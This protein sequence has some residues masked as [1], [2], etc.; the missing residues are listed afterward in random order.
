[1]PKKKETYDNESL[2]LLKDEERVR[3][4][5]A[6]IFGSDGL[7][8]CCHSFFEILSNAIDEAREGYG[9][10]IE[11]TR[12]KD[13]S[14]EVRDYGRGIPLD[15]NQKEQRY[16]WELVYCELYAGGKYNNNDGGMY[17]YSL[18]LNGLGACATQYSSEYMDV[19]VIRDKTKYTLHFEK[20]KN[21]GG[22]HKEE[23]KSTKTGST[24]HWK[25][26]T[27]V[28]TDIN[29][30]T[31]YFCDVL[32]KQAMTNAG[33]KFIFYNET[34]D[35]MQM[36]EYY[37]ENGIVDYLKDKV[38][39]NSFTQI[40]VW[41]AERK[42]RDREDKP[43]YK[44]KMQIAFCFSTTVNILEY[45]HN[46]SWLEHGGSPDKAVKNAFVYAID[47]YLKQNGKYNKNESKI[48]FVDVADCLA[49]VTTH[50]PRRQA[51]KIRQ[52]KPSTTNSYKK[53]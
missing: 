26:D 9:K 4:R 5:P 50:F 40:E 45:Y 24:V 16:N 35:G 32:E 15:F 48:T 3:K 53:L 28:F 44:V 22:L 18:G 27:E 19:E 39:E 6:V 30:P 51:M 52:K 10:V 21:I 29:I 43:E 2:T 42:G 25:P 7:D 38:G 17:E 47:H 13:K 49:L 37:Y 8:G 46:S 34:D 20:G 31:E 23:T 41:D 11:V 12:F 36:N 14:I 1:M 33:I